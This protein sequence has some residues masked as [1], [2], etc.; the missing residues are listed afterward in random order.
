MDTP[1][2]FDETINDQKKQRT[3]LIEFHYIKPLSV[4]K[5]TNPLLLKLCFVTAITATQLHA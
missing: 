5:K 4:V 3:V 1:L 2:T